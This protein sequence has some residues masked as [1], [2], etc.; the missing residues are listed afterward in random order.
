M[1]ETF[2]A[3]SLVLPGTYIRVRAEGLI[4]VGGISVGNI[5][6]VGEAEAVSTET[7]TISALPEAEAAFGPPVVDAA[8]TTLNLTAMIGEMMR[9]GAGVVFARAVTDSTDQ[10]AYSDAFAEIIKEDVQILVAPDLTTAA[11]LNVLP[12]LVDQAETDHQDLIC[13]I[14][15]DAPD[16]SGVADQTSDT[17]DVPENDRVIFTA[18]G[19]S[20]FN[21]AEPDVP[22]ALPGNYTAGPVAAKISSLAPHI[23]PTNKVMSGVSGLTQRFSY[24]ERITL[25]NQNVLVLE[26]RGGTRIVRGLTRDPGGFR[27]ITTRR[28]TDFAKAGI[29]Q[30]SN[31]FVGRLNNE[32][33]RAALH[34]ALDGFLTTMLVD[35]QITDYR[36]EVTATRRDE[37]EGRAI[38]NVL[39]QPTFSIDFV[40]VTI[41]LQ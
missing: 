25:V 29:R 38:V 17:G 11:A 18:P 6:I 33:V 15:S 21:P 13:V 30:V 39:L 16:A 26:Q 35:E 9:N 14:G 22:L 34:S 4:G 32:R 8:G 27:Q 36:L 20:V 12:P 3:S 24:G 41:V 19:Y 1:P 7:F 23:S 28:I 5:G 37:I 2:V 40:A 10:T 31:A